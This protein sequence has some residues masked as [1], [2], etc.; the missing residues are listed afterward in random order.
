M[1]RRS[2]VSAFLNGLAAGLAVILLAGAIK[3][4]TQL[5]VVAQPSY[6]F[7]TL[8]INP[9]TWNIGVTIVGSFVGLMASIAFSAQDAYITRV[10]LASKR[11][12]SAIFLRPLTTLRGLQQVSRGEINAERAVL[13]LL[14]VATALSSAVTVA[15]FAVQDDVVSVTNHSPSFSLSNLADISFQEVT[16]DGQFSIITP[17]LGSGSSINFS[18]FV[19]SFVYRSAFIEGQ[20]ANLGYILSQPLNDK[21][22]LP[23]QGLIGYT[24]YSDLWTAGVGINAASYMTFPGSSGNMPLP[25]NYTLGSLSGQVFGATVNVTCENR[26]SSYDI[27]AG[28]LLSSGLI[29]TASRAGYEHGSFRDNLTMYIDHTQDDL[30]PMAFHLN[31]SSSTGTATATD[32]VHVVLVTDQYGK[33]A[34]VFECAY[35]GREI[36]VNVNMPGPNMPLSVGSV[37]IQG[38]P[39]DPI[40]MSKLVASPLQ[41]IIGINGGGSI[42]AKAFVDAKY[43]SFGLNTTAQFG[44]VLARVLSQ[45]GQAIISA[46]KQS[47]EVPNLYANGLPQVKGVFLN[48]NLVVR[49]VGG[50][51]YGWI[52][53]YAVLLIGCLLGLI[54]ATVGGEAVDFDAQDSVMLLAQAMKENNMKSHTKVRFVQET[55]RIEQ[56]L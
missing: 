21:G 22:Y 7:T 48:V 10:R 29:V 36:V 50:G 35:K 56:S 39:I 43:N 30:L 28:S 13:V 25:T 14:T 12:I 32:P 55:D 46:V 18:P 26:T 19:E 4:K 44:D 51:S 38:P 33:N 42:I 15:L 9:S 31:A 1:R 17:I 11:G 24:T 49:R 5:V 41:G 6:G 23:V 3:L 54:R 34:Q 52:I 20:A 53:V 8:S 37:V 47:V 2:G 27:S 45:S 16:P 40:T